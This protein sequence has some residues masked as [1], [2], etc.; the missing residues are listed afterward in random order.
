MQLVEIETGIGINI[1]NKLQPDRNTT[2]AI[3]KVALDTAR[4]VHNLPTIRDLAMRG[5]LIQFSPEPSSETQL[6]LTHV[7]FD[8]RIVTVRVP[9][10]VH[11]RG[12]GSFDPNLIITVA[13]GAALCEAGTRDREMMNTHDGKQAIATLAEAYAHG[14]LQKVAC[15]IDST[16]EIDNQT[17]PRIR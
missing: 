14:L 9:R 7:D 4:A 16:L 13:V 1:P 6:A 2:A 3:I 17:N 8:T 5:A 15:A 10:S 11:Q 12:V